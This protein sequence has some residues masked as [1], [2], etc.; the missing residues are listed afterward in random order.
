ML[1]A[2]LE[3]TQMPPVLVRC[4]ASCPGVLSLSANVCGHTGRTPESGE[5]CL[6]VK[7]CSSWT[8]EHTAEWGMGHDQAYKICSST[9][10]FP[11]G[12]R[13]QV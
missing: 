13:T 4:R 2:E 5:Q 12:H 10:M 7:N 6:K 9:E 8:D 11:A 3:K 1:G